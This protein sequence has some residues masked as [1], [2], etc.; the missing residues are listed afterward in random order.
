[1]TTKPTPAPTRITTRRD[2][3][4]N[5][6]LRALLLPHLTDTARPGVQQTAEKRPA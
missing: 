5:A 2:P 3:E 6:R 4:A 1:M